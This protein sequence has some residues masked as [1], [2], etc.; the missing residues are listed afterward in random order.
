MSSP[1]L[2]RRITFSVRL[3]SLRHPLVQKWRRSA[4][5]ADI[6]YSCP[7]II[8]WKP[9]TPD[10]GFA[11]QLLSIDHPAM[12]ECPFVVAPTALAIL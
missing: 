12:G 6:D 9:P 1:N 5:I 10:C 3:G 7:M 4:V 11:G 2:R 8:M